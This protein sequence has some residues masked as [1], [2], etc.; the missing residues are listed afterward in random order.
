[1]LGPNGAGKSTLLRLLA[2]LLRPESGML[3]W[4]GRAVDWDE[5]RGRLHYVGHLDAIKPAL[6]VLENL[7]FWAGWQGADRPRAAAE[8]ALERLGIGHL[9]DLPGR[10]LSAGQKRR[11]ALA[12]ILARPRPVWLLDEPTVALDRGAVATLEGL[13]AEHRAGGGLVIAATHADFAMP[14]AAVFDLGAH[15]RAQAARAA[16]DEADEYDDDGAGA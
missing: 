1:L 12:R 6:S 9:A 13:I 10:V 4:E 8:A 7:A 3:A 11:L 5:H 14:G 15:K 2:G 16:E